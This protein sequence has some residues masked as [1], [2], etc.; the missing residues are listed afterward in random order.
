MP[1]MVIKNNKNST[2]IDNA[3]QIC[4]SLNRPISHLEK[5]YAVELSTSGS[6]KNET[7]VLKGMHDKSRITKLLAKFIKLV[8]LCGVCDNP[9]T[10]LDVRSKEKVV[11]ECRACG[12]CT[13]LYSHNH[14]LIKDICSSWVKPVREKLE[15]VVDANSD[16]DE[17][18]CCDTSDEAVKQRANEFLPK[19]IEKEAP[20]EEEDCEFQIEFGTPESYTAK[21]IDKELDDF[22]DS[23]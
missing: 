2:I 10:I 12:S 3:K 21:V 15:V 9:E 7:I 23:I 20:R 5:W 14:K 1:V 11:K 13:P 16:D 8:V 4:K 22:I 18:W 6:I 17:D 19:H